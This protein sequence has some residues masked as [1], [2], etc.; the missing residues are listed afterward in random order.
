LLMLGPC[1]EDVKW[2]AGRGWIMEFAE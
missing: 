2:V 1:T